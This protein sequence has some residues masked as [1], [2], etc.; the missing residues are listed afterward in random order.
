MSQS[1]Q[2]QTCQ[3]GR[4]QTRVERGRTCRASS[5]AKLSSTS[6]ARRNRLG[7]LPHRTSDFPSRSTPRLPCI[8]GSRAVER[9]V[10]THSVGITSVSDATYGA[11][12]WHL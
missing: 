5:R 6:S 11:S 7:S 9:R 4:L 8:L 3:L 2:E 1:G 12:V 10:D